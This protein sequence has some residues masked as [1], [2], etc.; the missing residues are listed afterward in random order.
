MPN[1]LENIKSANEKLIA[2]SIHEDWVD[3][4]LP[5]ELLKANSKKAKDA[6]N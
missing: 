3:I 4:G 5:N 1:L 6:G 2:Y